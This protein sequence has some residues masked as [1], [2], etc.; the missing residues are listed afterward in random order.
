MQVNRSSRLANS[1]QSWANEGPEIDSTKAADM[2]GI[3]RVRMIDLRSR[4]V[5][6]IDCRLQGIA[7][8][9]A[10]IA[11]PYLEVT[12]TSGRSPTTGRR[13]RVGNDGADD[14]VALLSNVHLA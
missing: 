7:V 6:E 11:H 13:A 5:L 3:R 10:R 2:S 14:T 8:D 1:T 4:S 12:F 9:P